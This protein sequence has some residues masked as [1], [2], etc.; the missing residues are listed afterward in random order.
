MLF[1]DISTS[2]LI[3]LILQ[4]ADASEQICTQI[5]HRLPDYCSIIQADVNA[6]KITIQHIQYSKITNGVIERVHRIE[7][8]PRMP[9]IFGRNKEIM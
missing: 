5:S 2:G 7:I 4:I 1:P 9:I 6:I 3:V 8:Y